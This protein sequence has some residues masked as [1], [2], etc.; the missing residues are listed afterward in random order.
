MM[1]EVESLYILSLSV[2]IIMSQ[3]TL[4]LIQRDGMD[5]DEAAMNMIWADT[6]DEFGPRPLIQRLMEM[7]MDGAAIKKLVD[8]MVDGVESAHSL[9][10]CVSKRPLTVSN[11]KEGGTGSGH[12][13]GRR[14]GGYGP[15]I[16]CFRRMYIPNPC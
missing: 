11:D 13:D 7:G 15:L 12:G 14:D 5:E 16:V 10:L 8:E 6:E 2:S 1:E 4:S 9:S 3:C